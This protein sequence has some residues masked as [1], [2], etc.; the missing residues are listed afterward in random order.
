MLL[1]AHSNPSATVMMRR[2]RK[3]TA[4]RLLANQQSWNIV[5]HVSITRNRL[6]PQSSK[7]VGEVIR[8]DLDAAQQGDT[9]DWQPFGN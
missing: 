9:P 6:I 4:G 2:L 8:A 3:D 1:I 5:N 7:L